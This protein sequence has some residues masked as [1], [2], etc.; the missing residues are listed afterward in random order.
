MES[1]SSISPVLLLSRLRTLAFIALAL[2]L[3]FGRRFYG[4]GATVRLLGLL[5]GPGRHCLFRQSPLH[6]IA[7]HHP[8]AF[9]AG[10]GALD[11]DE[12]A[13]D[14]H[15]GHFEILRGH[16][17]GAVMTMHFL[18]LEGLAGILAAAGTTERAVG[19]GDS[20]TRFEAAEIP[21]LHRAG[22]AAADGDPSNVNPLSWHEMIRLDH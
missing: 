18:V 1:A 3:F 13:L 17:I 9:R 15:L 11:H 6:G 4:S 7:H 14:V 5:D 8:A 20:V 21:P 2:R 16:A 22:E 19:D 10:H 12:A